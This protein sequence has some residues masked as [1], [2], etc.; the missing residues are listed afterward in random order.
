MKTI[1]IVF[2]LILCNQIIFCQ[3]YTSVNDYGW[4]CGIRY[5]K[6]L[7]IDLD[8]DGFLEGLFGESDGGIYY[9]VQDTINPMQFHLI[10]KSFS[11]I[12]VGYS[13]SPTLF[14]IDNDG[15]YDLIIGNSNGYLYHFE[16]ESI[17]TLNFIFISDDFNNIGD[18]GTASTPILQDIDNDGL[19]DLL[20]GESWG[21]LNHWEQ[22]S[23]NS[24]SFQFLTDQFNNIQIGEYDY[25]GNW[26]G[27]QIRPTLSDLD[28]DNLLDLV[29]GSGFYNRL[30][31]YEQN[32]EY[33]NMFS[34]INDSIN[35]ITSFSPY[36][37]FIDIDYDN[38]VELILGSSLRTNLYT[39]SNG[40]FQFHSGMNFGIDI[41]SGTQVI[42]TD[43]NDDNL[44]DIIALEPSFMLDN[45][46]L[47]QK[48]EFNSFDYNIINENWASDILGDIRS[49]FAKDIDNDG[50]TDI[51]VK[52]QWNEPYKHFEYINE[53]QINLFIYI[54]QLVINN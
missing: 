29:I 1:M 4:D 48:E 7:L 54:L 11:D 12:D 17:G 13:A 19:I 32:V 6:P 51:F 26:L 27:G 5:S 45:I 35:D 20:I 50:N 37:Y 16:Q 3:I 21:N 9:Y 36:P 43:L 14:D 31:H 30:F 28:D 53:N 10:S 18:I 34:F 52:N 49:I 8:D 38:Q 22:D 33:S 39:F 46:N 2:L 25:E 40:S 15:L 41:G 47:F 44:H 23:V 24:Y 42:I